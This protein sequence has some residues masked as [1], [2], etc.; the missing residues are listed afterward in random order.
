MQLQTIWAPSVTTLLYLIIFTTALGGRHA[1]PVAGAQVPFADFIAPGLIVM[2]DVC[3][4]EYM[5]HGHCG[6]VRKSGGAQSLGAAAAAPRGTAMKVLNKEIGDELDSMYGLVAGRVAA[7]GREL[8]VEAYEGAGLSDVEWTDDAVII[9]L[10]HGVPTHAIPHVLAI[11]LQHV[12]QT[13]DGYPHIAEPDEPH[14][15]GEAVKTLE[16]PRKA[17]NIAAWCR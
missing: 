1:V 7:S 14:A 2:G 3:L 9:S 5:S 16:E 13:L 8:V 11:A 4:C 10:H 17:W 6:I 15:E 12:R